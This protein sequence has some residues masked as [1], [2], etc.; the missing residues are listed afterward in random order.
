MHYLLRVFPRLS[1][2]LPRFGEIYS[3]GRVSLHPPSTA[4]RPGRVKVIGVR[5]TVEDVLHQCMPDFAVA[6]ILYPRFRVSFFCLAL[7]NKP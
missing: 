6:V 3:K 7:G 2:L 4:R 1:L 5:Y